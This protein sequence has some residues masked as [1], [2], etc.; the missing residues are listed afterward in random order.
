[1]NNVN[2]DHVPIRGRAPSYAETRVLVTTRRRGNG[3][4]LPITV[5]DPA[6]G[7]DKLAYH[8]AVNQATALM[9]PQKRPFPL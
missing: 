3:L 5:T 7:F 1:M 9:H 8:E 4:I 2:A 6:S